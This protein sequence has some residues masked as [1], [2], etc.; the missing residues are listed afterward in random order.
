[1]ENNNYVSTS[2]AARIMGIS[3]VAV[4]KKIKK[5]EIKAQKIGR[6][7]VV[8]KRS[9]GSIYQELMPAQEK[10]VLEAVRKAVGEYAEALKRL[11]RE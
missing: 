8:D 9:L 5:G 3:R 4:F 7:Y 10:K 2:E 6:N 1:M 11:G